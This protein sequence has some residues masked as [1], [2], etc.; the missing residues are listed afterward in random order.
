MQA[1]NGKK[2]W[3]D[4]R[5]VDFAGAHVHVLSHTL[6]YGVGVFVGIRAYATA[7]GPATFGLRVHAPLFFYSAM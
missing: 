7:R 5:L 6:H 3:M 4:G 2:I 1:S